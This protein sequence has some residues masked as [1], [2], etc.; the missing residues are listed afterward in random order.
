MSDPQP[1][2]MT[3]ESFTAECW[4]GEYL[5]ASRKS[6]EWSKRLLTSLALGNG[7]GLTAIA[8]T[9]STAG[10]PAGWQLHSAQA[11]AVGLACAGAAMW[12]RERFW[13]AKSYRYAWLAREPHRFVDDVKALVEWRGRAWWKKPFT[14]T[15]PLGGVDPKHPAMKDHWRSERWDF[16]GEAASVFSGV[17]FFA[18]LVLALGVR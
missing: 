5:E 16:A 4:E 6:E 10:P 9:L 1:R 11:F 17:A 3:P 12:F 7:A 13:T 14:P 18:A 8:S 15:K 2:R